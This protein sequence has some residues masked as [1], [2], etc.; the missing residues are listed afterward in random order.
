MF[1][2]KAIIGLVKGYQYIIS[3]YLGSNCR[4]YPSCSDYAIEAFKKLNVIKAVAYSSYR[5]LRCNPFCKGGE[6]YLFKE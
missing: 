6:D 5:I 4:F 2:N 3:P 1:I